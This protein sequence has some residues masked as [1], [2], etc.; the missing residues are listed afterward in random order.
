MQ[1]GVSLPDGGSAMENIAASQHENKR[2]QKQSRDGC[3]GNE[4]K[5]AWWGRNSSL[6]CWNILS[7][8]LC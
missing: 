1:N 4:Q 7:R 6:K 5:Q 3:Q 8:N 2:H